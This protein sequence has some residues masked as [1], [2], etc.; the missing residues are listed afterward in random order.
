MERVKHIRVFFLIVLYK[1]HEYEFGF[2]VEWIVE[3]YQITFSRGFHF[4]FL[5]PIGIAFNSIK[6]RNDA[7]VSMRMF[8][9]RS[10]FLSGRAHFIF[11]IQIMH[12]FRNFQMDFCFQLLSFH[13]TETKS[14]LW[15]LILS[16]HHMCD[17]FVQA[18]FFPFM[19]IKKG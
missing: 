15:Y 14:V 4:F 2:F 12:I 7:M 1:I 6:K 3:M 19:N 9:F 8:F 10:F 16:Y 13:F 18:V 11:M 17:S 5:L